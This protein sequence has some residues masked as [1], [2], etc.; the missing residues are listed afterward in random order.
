[1]LYLAYNVFGSR[2][3]KEDFVESHEK[4]KLKFLNFMG[5]PC[6]LIMPPKSPLHP[7]HAI[8]FVLKENNPLSSN[9]FSNKIVSNGDHDESAN[10]ESDSRKSLID[11]SMQVSSHT[12]SMHNKNFKFQL[13]IDGFEKTKLSMKYDGSFLLQLRDLPNKEVTTRPGYEQ[14]R[15]NILYQVRSLYGRTK[16]IFSSPLKIENNCEIKILILIELNEQLS[17]SDKEKLTIL[18][19]IQIP[20]S[21]NNETGGVRTFG[22]LFKLLPSK[23]YHVPLIVAY[24]YKLYATPDNLLYTPSLIFDIRG[25][26]F[27]VGE[28]SDIIMQRLT[29]NDVF[30]S[31]DINSDEVNILNH[32][33][34]Q[35]LRILRINVKDHKMLLPSMHANYIVALYPSMKISNCLP[36]NVRIDLDDEQ[37]PYSILIKDGENLNVHL[38]RAKLKQ[39]KIHVVNYLGASWVGTINWEKM[40]EEKLQTEKI[41]MTIVPNAEFALSDKHLA[42]C[43]G[44]KQPN[45]FTFYCPY[46]LVNKSGQPIKIRSIKTHRTFDIPD[47]SILLFDFKKVDKDNKVIMNVN[48][49]KW[50]KPFSLEAA[51]TTG[52]VNCKDTRRTYNFL[53]RI[54]MSNSSRSKLITF[55][56]FLSIVNQLDE[57]L[58][59]REWHQNDK[60]INHD[61]MLVEP[62]N[63]NSKPTAIW[64]NAGI[65]KE[66]YFLL[67]LKSGETKA[68]PLENPGRFVLKIENYKSVKQLLKV[69]SN[70]TDD[71]TNLEDGEGGDTGKNTLLTVLISGGS[72]NPVTIVVRKYQYGDSVAKFVN[73]CDNLTIS[74]NEKGFENVKKSSDS[75]TDSSKHSLPFELQPLYSMFFI[76]PELVNSKRDLQWTIGTENKSYDIQ[77]TKS[78]KEKWPFKIDTSNIF[79]PTLPIHSNASDTEDSLENSPNKTLLNV[80]AQKRK[81]KFGLPVSSQ[82]KKQEMDVQVSCVSYVEGMQRVVVFTTDHSW[83][84]IEQRK[85]ASSMEIFLNLKGIQLSLI[86][87]SNLEIAVISIKDSNSFWSLTPPGDKRKIFSEK[88]FSNEYSDWLEK[89]YSAFL[90][91]N[92]ASYVNNEIE[93]NFDQMIMN[94]P[95]KGNLKRSWVPGMLVQYRTSANMTSLKCCINKMQI[96]NQLPDAYFPICFYQQTKKSKDTIKN[97]IPFLDFSLFIEQQEVTQIYRCFDCI[98]QEFYFKMD[99]GFVFTLKDWYDSANETVKNDDKSGNFGTERENK[100]PLNLLTI[101]YEEDETVKNVKYDIKLTKEIM[102]YVNQS[103]ALKQSAHIRFDNFDISPILFN[104]SFSVNGKEHVEVNSYGKTDFILNFFLESIGATITE[105]KDVK[106]QFKQFSMRDTTKTMSEVYDLI[107][108]HYKIQVLNQAYVLILGLDVLGNPFG[109]VS[110]FSQGVT[111]LLYDPLLGVFS[112]TNDENKHKI[113]LEMS[114]KISLTINKTVSSAAGSGS[115]ITGSVGRILATCTLDND[116]KKVNLASFNQSIKFY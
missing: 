79:S 40:I 31:A 44:Y 15:Y 53:M 96:D 86:S 43:I 1:M 80:E 39:C 21:S 63:D 20:D 102:E 48:D 6:E 56:P 11:S 66:V 111:D 78:S 95:E 106:F 113:D 101:C 38:S 93:V 19:E 107:F 114:N 100:E 10:Y 41:E 67:K 108:D 36:I 33:D 91:N 37:T 58:S 54:T 50:S 26:N 23:I 7:H 13:S 22:L 88:F 74:I 52:M 70:S 46:W 57:N 29:H 35:F 92:K 62:I 73:L 105:F 77:L 84:D 81:N 5:E 76:W 83:A 99:K 85:E 89:G 65:G 109:L 112:K 16:V 97:F 82:L 104:L 75:S 116:Y 9:S 68:F 3:D 61:W 72:S 87:K 12:Q 115:L 32:S 51:G 18:R 24:K 4:P 47:D 60:T 71:I 8:G 17:Q 64:T 94:K 2:A 98:L 55:A 59:V 14:L 30:N 69:V 28:T 49:G 27:R 25:F 103:G 90:V 42:I 110:D 34:F 45:E